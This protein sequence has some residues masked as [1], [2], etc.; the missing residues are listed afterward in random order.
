MARSIKL[1]N[2]IFFLFCMY[3]ADKRAT[4]LNGKVLAHMTLQNIQFMKCE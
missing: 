4:S 1:E 2:E 3:G